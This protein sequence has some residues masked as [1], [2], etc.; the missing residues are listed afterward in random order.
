MFNRKWRMKLTGGMSKLKLTFVFM[1]TTGKTFSKHAKAGKPTNKKIILEGLLQDRICGLRNLRR[2]SKWKIGIWKYWRG[3]HQS[4]LCGKS[5]VIPLSHQPQC[6]TDSS[7]T[8]FVDSFLPLS[9]SAVNPDYLARV[10]YSNTL[11]VRGKAS[12]MTERC[13]FV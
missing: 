11:V 4:Q 7:E 3:H 10:F 9:R 12:G 5:T 13:S 1:C 8:F 6:H 2:V